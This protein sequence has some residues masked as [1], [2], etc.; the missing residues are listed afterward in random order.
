MDTEYSNMYNKI[1]GSGSLAT[2]LKPCNA[3]SNMDINSDRNH[4]N[5]SS[6]TFISRHDNVNNK[7]DN[8]STQSNTIEVNRFWYSKKNTTF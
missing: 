1:F 4:N 7:N 3:C 6:Y 5:I 2:S 8:Y